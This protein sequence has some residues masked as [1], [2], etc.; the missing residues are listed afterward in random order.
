MSWG[1]SSLIPSNTILGKALSG[2]ISGAVSSAVNYVKS[3]EIL[4]DVKNISTGN[5]AGVVSKAVTG[6]QGNG[7]LIGDL[8]NKGTNI[9]SLAPSN[10]QNAKAQEIQTSANVALAMGSGVPVSQ[11]LKLTATPTA[12]QMSAPP[13]QAQ[14]ESTTD[15]GNNTGY[16]L[17]G[18]LLIGGFLLLR[19]K[20]TGRYVKRYASR[21]KSY[22]RRSYSTARRSYGRAMSY[23]KRRY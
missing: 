19:N 5:V 23:R 9:T 4:T 16:Y 11:A 1:L 17:I 2:N 22:A 15:A 8:L 10:T 21:A 12:S 13:P 3:G 14:S 20:K 18:G 7:N 6:Y